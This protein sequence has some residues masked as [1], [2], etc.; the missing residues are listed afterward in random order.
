LTIVNKKVSQKRWYLRKGDCNHPVTVKILFYCYIRRF[1]LS[2]CSCS[3][4]LTHDVQWRSQPK[5]LE[6]AKQLW[7]GARCL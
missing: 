7:R 2:M 5:N 1:L 3:W 4:R 6:G